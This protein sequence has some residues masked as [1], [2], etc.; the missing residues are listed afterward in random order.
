MNLPEHSLPITSE[1]Q[2]ASVRRW[3]LLGVVALGLAGIFAGMLANTKSVYFYTA[4]VAHVDLSVLVWFLS[5]SCL[6]MTLGVPWGA[7]VMLGNA[8]FYS[9][10]LGTGCIAFSAF[11]GGT[12]FQNNYIPVIHHPVFFL[13]LA[14]IFCGVMCVVAQFLLGHK[15]PQNVSSVRVGIVSIAAIVLMA[16]FC[17]LWSYHTMPED[18]RGE[19]YYEHIFWAG[20]HVLQIAYAQLMIIAW[21]WLA[22]SAGLT[23][24]FGR[25]IVL[26]CYAIGLLAGIV[27]VG[28]SLLYPPATTEHVNAFTALMKHGNGLP[29]II[30]GGGLVVALFK[31]SGFSLSKICL[32][33]SILL[34]AIGGGLGYLISGSNVIVPAH[35]HGS[36]VGVTI[37]L[38][39]LA[40]ILLPKL[41]FADVSANTLA[42]VQ[43]VL[44]GGGQLCWMAGMAVLGAYGVA[45]KT[46]GSADSMGAFAALLK[47]GGDGLSLIGGLLFVYVVLRA[48]VNK[49]QER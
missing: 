36:I 26:A 32:V 37:A 31:G 17:F 8:G 38:M 49:K 14:L 47:H 39:G 30:M 15:T 11:L 43:P 44:Y 1:L 6:V 23:L 7:W 27:G 16:A 48:V 22:E 9:M 12:P 25:R 29:A 2:R 3:L 19:S 40:Y 21:L 20:G 33:M 45:R 46:P 42:K 34:F 18:I 35:Y 4:L 24:P 28:F 41:G 10:V 5:F 13:G